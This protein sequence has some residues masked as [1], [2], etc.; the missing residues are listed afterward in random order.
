MANEYREGLVAGEEQG[1]R[2]KMAGKP[3]RSQET[4]GKHG[5]KDGYARG[6]SEGYDLAPSPD[7]KN[8]KQDKN[9]GGKSVTT[10]GGGPPPKP[11]FNGLN[12]ILEALLGTVTQALM[13]I[14]GCRLGNILARILEALANILGSIGQGPCEC[15]RKEQESCG[16]CAGDD[17]KS[18]SDQQ[19]ETTP[20]GKGSGSS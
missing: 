20:S 19:A 11:P 9:T 7:D 12:E 5:Y 4:D 10:T 14:G 16:S 17:K 15:R 13:A 8:K 6:Y 2:D 18:G 3:K 1:Q